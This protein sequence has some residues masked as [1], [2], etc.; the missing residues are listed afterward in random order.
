MDAQTWHF[1]DKS[2][3]PDGPW[4]AEPDKAVWVDEAT[5]LDCM[6][7]R[8]PRGALCG[9]VAVAEGH[10]Y[11]DTSYVDLDVDV[12]GGLTYAA[13]CG[14][15]K[16]D[17]SGLCHVPAEGR[18]ERVFWFGFDCAHAWDRTPMPY[19]VPHLDEMRVDD[20]VYRDWAYVEGE[21]RSLARQL[22]EMSA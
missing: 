21:V 20:E 8:N 14:E 22:A 15:H 6:I 1:V 2:S 18:P 9:Y 7:H 5:G 19:G 12:H 17:G 16:D 4:K 13:F 11:F 10:P 3:W